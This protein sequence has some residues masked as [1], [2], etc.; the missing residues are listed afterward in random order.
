MTQA[1]KTRLGLLKG[2]WWEDTSTGLP[3]FQSILGKVG[4]VDNISLVDTLIKAQIVGT[5]DVTGI[6]SFSST[7][8]STA[9]KYSFSCTA[10]TK[11]GTVTV[12]E[13]L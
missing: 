3:L 6:E 5:T 9:R 4:T 11:Y 12:T 7:F 8:D 2:E 10:N 1:I 13:T